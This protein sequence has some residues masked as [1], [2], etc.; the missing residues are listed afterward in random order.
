LQALVC[1]ALAQHYRLW[2]AT[3]HL[4]KGV[5]LH[6]MVDAYKNVPRDLFANRLPPRG[7]RLI[8]LQHA[9]TAQAM[10]ASRSAPIGADVASV[11]APELQSTL[12]SDLAMRGCD[13]A[14]SA[15]WTEL[16]ADMRVL[17]PWV[18]LFRDR[19]VSDASPG[20][21]D[22]SQS[23]NTA[24][25]RYLVIPIALMLR[26]L[27][28]RIVRGIY[29]I[30]VGLALLLAYQMAFPAYPRRAM[31]AVTWAY[32]FVG[33]STAVA[34][35]VSVERDAVMSR[36]AGTAAGKIEWDAAFLQRTVLP[37][38]FALLTL[39]AVQFPGAGNTLLNWLR[40]MQTAL[41]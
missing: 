8:H 13:I 36:L 34:T 16:V 38:L 4:L 26:E 37:I 25:E 2:R 5:A 17:V 7:P 1:I 18:P 6:P 32:M 28:A 22:V 33:V 31:M 15:T 3:K 14:E 27:T 21:V 9:A 30:F 10:F 20:A 12:N 35:A 39:F 40:P 19:A 24:A 11:Q 29:A 41:P 23:W